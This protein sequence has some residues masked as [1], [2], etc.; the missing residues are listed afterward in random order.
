MRLLATSDKADK[1]ERAPAVTMRTGAIAR[2]ESRLV[3]GGL[4]EEAAAVDEESSIDEPAS[5]DAIELNSK[6]GQTT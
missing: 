5:E 6:G 3:E 4:V 2:D 1:T